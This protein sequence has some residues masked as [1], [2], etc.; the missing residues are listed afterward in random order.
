[1]TALPNLE[2]LSRQQRRFQE[3]TCRKRRRGDPRYT[4]PDDALAAAR[5]LGAPASQISKAEAM[6]RRGL[7][8]KARRQAVCGILGAQYDCSDTGCKSRFFRAYGCKCRYCLRC[9]PRLHAELFSK[10]AAL[11]TVADQFSFR[12]GYVVA[13]LDFTTKKLERMPTRNEVREFNACI[14][15]F[16]RRLE[17]EL[18][19]DRKQYGLVYCDEFGGGENTN[20]HAHALYV[21]PRLPR[22]KV[23]K[24]K[25]LGR[26][27]EWWRDS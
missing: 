14:K 1:M 3:R 15:R 12:P 5:E 7:R 24:L 27:A 9:G 25:R 18:N 16:C 11:K 8:A 26:L 13:K 17:R 23:R 4:L 20:L 6:V 22:P 19:L 2:S 10:H 21:G